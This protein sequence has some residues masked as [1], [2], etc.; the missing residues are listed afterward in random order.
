MK[1]IINLFHIIFVVA[2]FLYLGFQIYNQQ[3]IDRNMGVLLIIL[4]LAIFLY[5][6]YRFYTVNK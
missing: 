3:K 1:G 2:L 5:H 4:A 6:A